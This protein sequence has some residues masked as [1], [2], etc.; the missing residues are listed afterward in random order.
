M[1]KTCLNLI[2]L[3]E[4]SQELKLN[5]A[6]RSAKL[7]FAVKINNECNFE[8]FIQKFKYLTDIENLQFDK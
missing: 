6:S 4:I 1:L 2:L 7:R 8:E 3:Q 5:P